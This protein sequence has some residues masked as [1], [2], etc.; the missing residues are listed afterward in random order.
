MY[1]T[2]PQSADGV[3]LAGTNAGIFRWDGMN[4]Q[5]D[6]KIVKPEKKTSYVVH[7]GKRAKQE[8][9]VMVPGGQIDA[10]VSDVDASGSIWYA[11]TANGVY[12][13]TDQGATWVGGP[14][15][16]KTEYRAVAASGPM[17]VA[18][19]R[20]ALAWSEDG[21]KNWQPLAMPQKLT[22]L[23]SIAMAGNGSLWLGGREGV[24]YSEDHGQNWNEMSN[25]PI[26]DISGLS[27]DPDLKRVVV[28]SWASSW[29]LAVDPADRTF[30]FWDPGWKV[31]HVR[32]MSGR[33]LAAT[34]YNG[35]VM[36]PQ[37][38]GLK[39]CRCPDPLELPG[40]WFSCVAFKCRT[41]PGCT[42]STGSAFRG[43]LPTPKQSCIIS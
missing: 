11:A 43:R 16:G 34:P 27:Y 41:W 40:V 14:V 21:G 35:V 29:V 30:K 22:W 3:I 13:S 24:F 9:T 10:R 2:S 17:V 28:T 26:S 33:L 6:G 25:L 4:W 39:G 32:S 8:T 31:R 1:L 5:P 36:E 37:K 23:Q 38:R 42:S 7:K 12:A 20:T 18:A 15:L 19:E